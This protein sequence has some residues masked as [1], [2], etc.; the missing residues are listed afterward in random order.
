M[1]EFTQIWKGKYLKLGQIQNG[2][3]YLYTP[4]KIRSSLNRIMII[5]YFL[6]FLVPS[7]PI[8]LK[9]TIFD[10]AFDVQRAQKQN[11][12]HIFSDTCQMC[13]SWDR[14]MILELFPR[15][16]VPKNPIKLN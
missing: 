1:Q 9:W 12:C 11:G 16:W 8:K 7:N 10:N 5:E 13:S 4:Y 6:M 15:F 14:M 3:Q 2:R